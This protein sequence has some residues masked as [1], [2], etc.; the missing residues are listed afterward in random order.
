MKRF[1]IINTVTG[2]VENV[3]NWDGTVSYALLPNY[4]AFE[5]DT[6]QIGQYIEGFTAPQ[7]EIDS[8]KLERI[9]R[10]KAEAQERIYAIVPAWK[11]TNLIARSIEL[12]DIKDERAWT[13]ITEIEAAEDAAIRAIWAQVK[14]IRAASNTAEAAVNAAATIQEINAVI[15]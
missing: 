6:L 12:R 7:E 8:A 4:D 13:E 3:I 9:T 14:A 11:Q 10:I 2:R 1:A 15:F 5:S